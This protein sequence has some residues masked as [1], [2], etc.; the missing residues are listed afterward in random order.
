[1]SD[2]EETGYVNFEAKIEAI[3]SARLRKVDELYQQ[4]KTEE[5]FLNRSFK[6]LTVEAGVITKC[7]KEMKTLQKDNKP[8]TAARDRRRAAREKNALKGSSRVMDRVFS[9]RR[10]LNTAR[11]GNRRKS[12]A[13]VGSEETSI[14]NSRKQS[15]NDVSKDEKKNGVGKRDRIKNRAVGADSE[16]DEIKIGFNRKERIKNR[17]AQIV[18]EKGKE[19]EIKRRERKERR[20][21]RAKEEEN[22]KA[23][24][25]KER[26]ERLE[27]RRQK[28]EEMEKKRKEQEE[29]DQERIKNRRAKRE[30]ARKRRETQK[31]LRE[32]AAKTQNQTETPNLKIS[33]PPEKLKPNIP[34]RPKRSSIFS[35]ASKK[36]IPGADSVSSETPK[37]SIRER[38][39]LEALRKQ[40][41]EED[42]RKKKERKRKAKM[43][44]LLLK[45]SKRKENKE[46]I[47]RSEVALPEQLDLAK[48]D[49]TEKHKNQNDFLNEKTAILK[50]SFKKKKA[51]AVTVAEISQIKLDPPSK[52]TIENLD[53]LKIKNEL[54]LERNPKSKETSQKK[55]E[56][57][58]EEDQPNQY[59][60][61]KN[62]ISR[63]LDDQ[64]KNSK[65]SLAVVGSG[66]TIDSKV[67]L[68]TEKFEEKLNE[69]NQ[70]VIIEGEKT[71]P[72]NE[73]I[74][75]TIQ[76]I[77]EV[78]EEK[79]KEDV[80]NEN[81]HNKKQELSEK[82]S[83]EIR[84]EKN[85]S[86]SSEKPEQEIKT[87]KKQTGKSKLESPKS[88][89]NRKAT[90]QKIFKE[91]Q[92]ISKTDSKPD[93]PKKSPEETLIDI[94]SST[95]ESDEPLPYQKPTSPKYI[96]KKFS[97]HFEKE[98]EKNQTELTA[99]QEILSEMRKY[100]PSISLS[101]FSGTRVAQHLAEVWVDNVR[102]ELID[103]E[104][105][106]GRLLNTLGT[107]QEERVLAIEK[108][109]GKEL[110]DKTDEM[111]DFLNLI[112][113]PMLEEFE[114]LEEVED[115]T[116]LGLDGVYRLF[117]YM[118][119]DDTDWDIEIDDDFVEELFLFFVN[120]SQ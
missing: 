97:T 48:D 29:A 42:Q 51:K 18:D 15:V 46:K 70:K 34:R 4:S 36:Q 17:T 32:A 113:T 61:S 63:N 41:E 37:M 109:L 68:A 78:E 19:R 45:R 31:K 82:K 80:T 55:E 62:G 20:E 66:E 11:A 49:Q 9:S 115:F 92:N 2:S 67:S 88:E 120:I 101:I 69:Q 72:K 100:E 40:Q 26:K 111:E 103:L 83:N 86:L 39:K 85:N 87:I 94:F 119:I 13:A 105:Q 8:P 38:R 114:D 6:K 84:S 25:E 33:D 14:N 47:F 99:E 93:Q 1:M 54:V 79:E 104:V 56:N 65:T 75:I 91:D 116:E 90:P 117:Y 21:A 12:F 73:N 118:C 76:P 107:K 98:K 52:T 5:K 64:S 7:L 57:Q 95:S 112:T 102:D 43:Q 89:K 44:K 106:R 30:E 27:K 77:K 74:E 96:Y 60:G 16:R 53:N 108:S 110:F 81:G 71:N 28:R 58:S 50:P 10:N 35:S 24:R 23:Q 59:L 3:L 22:Q